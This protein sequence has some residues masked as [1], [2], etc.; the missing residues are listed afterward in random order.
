MSVKHWSLKKKI[1]HGCRHEN[2]NMHLLTSLTSCN[3][4]LNALN[5]DKH[6]FTMWWKDKGFAQDYPAS[7]KKV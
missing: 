1:R 3:W 2:K 6:P 5:A 4:R 7:C